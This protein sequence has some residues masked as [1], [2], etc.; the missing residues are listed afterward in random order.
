MVKKSMANKQNTASVQNVK[1]EET[2][3]DEQQFN[4][5]LQECPIAVV[6]M[7]SIFADAKNLEDYW[8]NIFES[9]DTIRDVPSDR[10]AVD[11][12]YD[13]DPRKADKTYCKRGAFLPEID[14]DP[15]EFGLPPNILELTD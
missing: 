1:A 2:L 11:D 6:G 7:A 3:T 14:F 10:W 4:S 8:D 15:M 12:Y 5:R 9:V 13:S